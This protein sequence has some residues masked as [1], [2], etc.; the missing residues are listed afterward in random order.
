MPYATVA[1][2]IDRLGEGRLQRLTDLSDP[3]LG[4]MDEAVTLKALE[5]ATAEID[6]YLAGRYTLPLN[7]VP[8]V[9]KVHACGIAHY[10]LLGGAASDADREDYKAIIKYLDSVGSGKIAL[11]P[12]KDVPPTLGAGTVLFSSGQ[13][14]M[15]REVA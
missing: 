3:P 13:K 4:V 9:L 11:M 1:D 2:L 5:D 8:P 6:S 10:R 14:V 12:P 7:P 15:G